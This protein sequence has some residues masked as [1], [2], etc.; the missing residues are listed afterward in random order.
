L[1]QEIEKLT[2]TSHVVIEAFD[3]ESNHKKIKALA[4]PI[5]SSFSANTVTSGSSTELTI[6]GSNFGTSRG[7]GSVGFKDANF[8]DGRY[9][10]IP[11]AWGYTSWSNTQ[12]KVI[13]P[14]RAGTGAV[15]VINNGGES[16]ESSVDL[17]I[18]WSHLNVTSFSPSNIADTPFFE[19][20]H[21][22]DNSLGGY[23]WQMSP[24]FASST[25][26]VESFERSLNEWKCETQ[27]NWEIGINAPNHDL[28]SD[29]VNTV[30]WTSYTDSRL[31][32]CYSRYSGCQT[33][34][35][36]DADWFVT[37]LDIEFDSTRNWY[38]GT[39]APTSSQFDFESVATHELGHGHQLGHVRASEKVMHYSIGNGQRKP[40]LSSTDIAAGSYVKTKSITT[41]ICGRS[42]MATGTC[43]SSPP[44]A[45]IQASET[46]VCR[47]VGIV[48]SD[49]STGND[50]T[51]VSWDF[52]ADATPATASSSGPHTLSYS[53][54]GTK[55]I[56]LIVANANGVDTATIAVVIRPTV[57]DE[58]IFTSFSD[59]A[60]KIST[61]YEV[62]FLA[63]ASDYDW[64]I[65]GGG[66]VKAQNGNK[67]TVE[68]TTD[69]VHA[70]S[71]NGKNDC[72]VGPVSTEDIL[73]LTDPIS[74]FTST[75][76]GV[77]VQF[78]N[79]STFAESYLWTFGDGATSTEE[80]PS[81]RFA[82]KGDFT[83]T[84]KAIN[85]CADSTS[86]ESFILNYRVG[87]ETLSDRL[88]VYPNPIKV[89]GQLHIEGAKFT[90]YRLVD[91]HGALIQAGEL[92]N[93]KVSIGV[94]A[95][96]VYTLELVSAND[97]ASYRLYIVE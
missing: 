69:G 67:F 36:T 93:N 66:D 21:I 32:V 83:T 2:G 87:V 65:S 38:F 34:G 50:I 23:T 52:G 9:Y 55:T 86:E 70:I 84:L 39:V 97:A 26:A 90:A 10:Y 54:A 78:T 63:G 51:S 62:A 22:D 25:A 60:C 45:N 4:P 43:I 5:V 80:S 56:R 24:S 44:V 35:A 12:I 19:I 18:D 85:R 28:G 89:G 94:F 71:V 6:N 30:R 11:T 53:A 17:T 37:E 72:G 59:S 33:S 88:M 68:W 14:S 61:L 20:Q 81:H 46:D 3:A 16:G 92:E 91:I 76:D 31:G 15:Q 29:G 7:S 58:P 49:L 64:S 79:A 48:F 41:S 74:L 95:V 13:V 27:M 1:Y 75:E 57:D 40:A 42:T 96:G 73:V 8:G 82:D 77:D 47:G